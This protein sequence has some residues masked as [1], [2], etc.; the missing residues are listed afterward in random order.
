[1]TPRLLCEDNGDVTSCPMEIWIGLVIVLYGDVIRRN[2]VLSALIFNLFVLTYVY[3]FI[4][5]LMSK[6]QSHRI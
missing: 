6:I 2:S 5:D 4:Q 3:F 1:M